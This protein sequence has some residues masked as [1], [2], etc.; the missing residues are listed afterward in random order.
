[1][2]GRENTGKLDKNESS[3]PRFI[4][5]EKL[6][7][8]NNCAIE[9]VTKTNYHMYYDMVSWRMKGVELTVEEKILTN[10]NQ[11]FDIYKELELPGFSVYAAL[12][13]GR[14]RMARQGP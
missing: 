13:D 7:Q 1:M 8:N 6:M 9:R 3:S 14:W 5:G 10:R 4:T 11:Y 12:C 2:A